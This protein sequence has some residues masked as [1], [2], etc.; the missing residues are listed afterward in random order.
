MG[1]A[2]SFKTKDQTRLRS[3]VARLRSL[4]FLLGLA[5]SLLFPLLAFPSPQ[6]G[7]GGGEEVIGSGDERTSLSPL[8]AEIRKRIEQAKFYPDWA[9][10]RGIEGTVELLFTLSANGSVV[11]VKI[12]HSSGS[13]LLDEAAIEAVRRASPYP[14]MGDWPGTLQLQL[15]ITYRLSE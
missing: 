12:L 11:E 13:P 4:V 1:P 6:G 2:L 10:S 8:S 15:P 3:P 14:V 7:E 9:R 5:V